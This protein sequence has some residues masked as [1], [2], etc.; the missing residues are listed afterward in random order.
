MFFLKQST[1]YSVKIGP[2]LDDTDGKTPE[3]VLTITSSEVRLSKD[4]GDF[5]AKNEGT[6]ASHDENGYY[7]ALINTTDTNTLGKLKLAVTESGALPVWHDYMVLPANVYDSI[8]STD[9]LQVDTVQ[10][11]G[12]TQVGDIDDLIALKEADKVIDTTG[13][14]WVLEYRHKTT[15]VVLL[16]QTMENT[17]GTSITSTNN[18]LGQLE[19]E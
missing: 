5:A 7:D 3:T 8:F 9:K 19:L 16:R 13:D 6:S 11:G 2:F 14:P 15:K 4:G 10:I 17:S 18:V 1:A 12:V